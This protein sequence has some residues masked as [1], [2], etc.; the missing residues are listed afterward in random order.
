M[1]HLGNH[2]F[3]FFRCVFDNK[4]KG[5]GGAINLGI[6]NSDGDYICIMMADLS[7][8]TFLSFPF[9]ILLPHSL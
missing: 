9:Y 2:P 1:I 8:L 7:D 3:T 6:E 4:K 5:L